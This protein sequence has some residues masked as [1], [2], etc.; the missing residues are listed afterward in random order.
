MDGR[1]VFIWLDEIPP[2]KSLQVA[3]GTQKG[4]H[5]SYRWDLVVQPTQSVTILNGT[6]IHRGAGGPGRV[7]FV[8]SLPRGFRAW[9]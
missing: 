1:V 9:P 8:V 6:T 3:A 7:V 2:S 4:Y 5:D